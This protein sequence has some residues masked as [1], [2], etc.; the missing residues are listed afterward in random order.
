MEAAL[1]TSAA[2]TLKDLPIGIDA[3]GE[4]EEFDSMGKVEVPADRYWG[5]QTQRSL[6][7]FSIGDDRMPKSV[8]HA[9]GYVKKACALV[10]HDA[11]R[12]PQWKKDAIVRA[13]DETISGKLDDHYP[14][15][16]WQT[17]SGTQSNMNVNEVISNR[18]IQLLGGVLGSQHPVGPNDDVNMGQSSNDTFP[19]AMHVAAVFTLD[20]EL[21]PKVGALCGAIERKA[22]GW[23]DVVKIGRTHLEDAVPL[24]VG[25]EWLGWAGQIRAALAEVEASRGGLYELAVG[26]T[27]VGTGLNAPPGFAKDVAAKIAELTGKP[28]VTAPNKFS[29]QG[30]LDAIVR[31]HAA[32]RGLAVALMKIA[33]DMRWLAS[34]PRCGLGELKLPD[35]EPGSSIMPGKVNPTQ[36]E[37]MVMIAIQV[38]GDDAAVAF[39]GSQGN[40]E[41]NAMRP[42]IINNF[43]HSVRV[44]ADGSEKFR[45]YSVEGTELNRERIE[46]YVKGSV[47]LVTALS[48]VI[49]Y[50]NAAHIAEKAIADGTTLKEAALAS[51]KVTEELFDKTIVPLNMVGKGLAG[52]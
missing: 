30:S 44:L 14:L 6:Q 22:R 21:L 36:C 16:V 33:N 51:G 13:A 50:Q 32:L 11:G 47:M 40:F 19:T 39:A 52:A 10:N 7:H 49:G 5:A 15:Y 35:N 2:P 17:G 37:A 46:Q 42:I 24:T 27:A 20:N 28:F 12:L 38:L 4:R 31:A 18:A 48:P 9:Y 34:G 26:G 41:L 25:Q 29:A 1:E 8:Y 3:A 43:L 45:R 23:M